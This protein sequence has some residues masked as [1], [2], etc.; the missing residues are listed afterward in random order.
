MSSQ[1]NSAAECFEGNTCSYNYA[2]CSWPA[3]TAGNTTEYKAEDSIH[4]GLKGTN[5][6]GPSKSLRPV[7]RHPQPCR[8]SHN[9]SQQGARLFPRPVAPAAWI[10]LLSALLGMRSSCRRIYSEQLIYPAC[11]MRFYAAVSLYCGAEFRL[12]VAGWSVGLSDDLAKDTCKLRSKAQLLKPVCF[13]RPRRLC[14]HCSMA[15]RS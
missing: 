12:P 14:S 11:Y 4:R 3:L 15:R 5:T 6:Q 1:Q 9:Y 10:T 2:T 7:E 13:L 8:S